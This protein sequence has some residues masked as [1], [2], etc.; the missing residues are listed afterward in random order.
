MRMTL[1]AV[2]ATA[3]LLCSAGAAL[4]NG[5][6]A[7]GDVERTRA[8]TEAMA[9]TANRGAEAMVREDLPEFRFV[10]GTPGDYEPVFG[11]NRTLQFDTRSG[12]KAT[13]A[14]HAAADGAVLDACETP[15]A[16]D[17]NDRGDYL[18]SFARF[19]HQPE[20][21]ILDLPYYTDGMVV[22]ELG[23]SM[24]DHFVGAA[25]CWAD[26]KTAGFPDVADAEP[27]VRNAATM[28]QTAT[29]SGHCVLQFD[30][31]ENGWLEN[32][33]AI[34]CTEPHFEE[35]AL[36]AARLWY[37]IPMTHR[38]QTLRQTG[39]STK[40]IFRLSDENGGLIGE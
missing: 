19:G 15:C 33:R 24:I 36:Q 6:P 21:R 7:P 14:L 29:R 18:V 23:D 26:H 37:Y 3:L 10:W 31:T 5:R 13:A 8:Q 39:L 30:V 20:L 32:E 2:A 28:P 12:K 17:V 34:S 16:M 1:S 40:V 11:A 38:G 25:Q 35:P 27:C 22:G 9:R 4:A